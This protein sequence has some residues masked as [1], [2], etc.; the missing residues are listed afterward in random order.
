MAVGIIHNLVFYFNITRCTTQNS[1]SMNISLNLGKSYFVWILGQMTH[2]VWILGQM[3]HFVW[4]GQM[5]KT[6]EY[7]YEYYLATQKW[8]NTNTNIIWPP[9]NDRILYTN[10][11]GFYVT[12]SHYL[13]LIHFDWYHF[14][15][16]G[17]GGC[18]NIAMMNRCSGSMIQNLMTFY[19]DD[20]WHTFS[21]NLF[22]FYIIIQTTVD[23][24]IPSLICTDL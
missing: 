21:I 17:F 14:L 10:T 2:F 7:E 18:T 3:S 20:W 1:T 5:G 22:H 6:T 16:L 11:N 24:F 13:G 4:I 12:L 19:Y 9:N 23:F 8:P 15:S